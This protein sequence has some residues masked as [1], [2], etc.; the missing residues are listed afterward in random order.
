MQRVR[1]QPN[2]WLDGDLQ[3]SGLAYSTGDETDDE[4]PSTDAAFDNDP[5]DPETQLFFGNEDNNQPTEEELQNPA[6]RE[7][8]EWHAMLASVLKGDVVKQEKQRL[9]GTSE[10]KSTSEISNEIWTGVRAKMYG[11]S[12]PMQKKMIE[13]VRSGISP[14]IEEVIGFEIKGETEVGKTAVG[15]SAGR[16]AQD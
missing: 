1:Q 7:R 11:R 10:Q 14:L 4:S 5:Y 9:I 16:C 3:G 8:L 6:N 2:E 13:D 12:I 15:T